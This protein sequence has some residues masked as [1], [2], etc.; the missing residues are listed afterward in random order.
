MKILELKLII[1][2]QKRRTE[3]ASLSST[4]AAV[5][6][7]E[8]VSENIWYPTMSDMVIVHSTLPSYK[9]RKNHNT[10]SWLC[11]DLV[12]VISNHY[13]DYDLL[14]ML[15]FVCSRMQDRVSV[16]KTKQTIHVET[17]GLKG[18]IHFNRKA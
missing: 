6:R 11:E 15:T 16:D 4:D 10:G 12:N 7:N 5:F 14:T 17:F 2:Y 1:L 8:E 18:L 3:S 9:S 13:Q